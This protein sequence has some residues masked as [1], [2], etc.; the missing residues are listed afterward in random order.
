MAARS[1]ASGGG[2]RLLSWNV[3][4]L[5][6]CLGKGFL[7]WVKAETPDLLALQ[8]VRARPEQLPGHV[9]DD[10]AALGYAQVWHAAARPGYSGT[11][12]FSR[13]GGELSPGLG[14]L[15]PAL[16]RW[17][18]EG[19][20]VVWRRDKLLL[21]GVYFPNGTSGDERLAYKLEFYEMFQSL[22]EARQAAGDSLIVCGDV[23]TAHREI[24]LA[25]PKENRQTSGFLPVECAW[26]DRLTQGRAQPGL[27]D[28]F[29]HLHPDTAAR[30]SW[31][32][33]RGGARARNVGWR[34]DYVFISPD[35][36]PRLRRAEILDQVTGSDHCPVELVLAP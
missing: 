6:A 21:L 19:R 22:C 33:Q 18:D 11:A 15:D 28:S 17:D 20:V 31:W 13:V 25:R 23:N 36:L 8:E 30:Y 3:N 7:D 4:G 16:A 24:D 2:L 32:S 10:L 1:S 5:R 34:L 29:R 35:L 26:L 14:G 27:V 9:A 12:L